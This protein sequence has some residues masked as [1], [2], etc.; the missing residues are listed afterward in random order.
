MTLLAS[1]IFAVMEDASD[2][3][4]LVKRGDL[5]IPLFMIAKVGEFLLNFFETSIG[6]PVTTYE[7]SDW[8]QPVNLLKTAMAAILLIVAIS[9]Q[10]TGIVSVILSMV[11]WQVLSA[12]FIP[13]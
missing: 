8:K 1:A 4:E 3:A 2:M 9:N 11:L 12:V 10:L 13:L 7:E 6:I 5:E